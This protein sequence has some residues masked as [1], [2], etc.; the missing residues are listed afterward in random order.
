M[1]HSGVPVD[2]QDDNGYTALY[3]AAFTNHIEVVEE[4]LK[5]DPD[6]NIQNRYH[7][8]PLH[9][10]AQ[11]NSIDIMQV[12]LQRGA[13]P[14]I[15]NNKNQTALD[16]ALEFN[17]QEAMRFLERYQV[18]EKGVLQRQMPGL[19]FLKTLIFSRTL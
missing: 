12:L 10:A 2:S 15:R 17:S 19:Q 7:W 9:A 5:F 13:K 11:V 8:T 18:S 3:W 4:L 16:V 1:I 14:S 6:V